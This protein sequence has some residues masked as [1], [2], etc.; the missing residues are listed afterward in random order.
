MWIVTGLGNPGREYEE[1]R[2]NIGFK[3]VE[4]LAELGSAGQWKEKNGASFVETHIPVAGKVL[5]VK[6][7]TYMNRSGEPLTRIA[8]FYKVEAEQIGVVHDEVDIPFGQLRVKAG[9]GD[10]GHNGLKSVRS[11]LGSADFVRIRVGVGRP[12]LNDEG[13]GPDIAD[14]VL[15]RFGT[16]DI[17]ELPALIDRSA[18]AVEAVIRDGVKSAQNTFN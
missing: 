10:G 7:L 14:W 8:S 2:H 6:P 12:V 18:Q 4:R 13:K 1:T 11:R 17:R 3:V 16:D 5:L 15:G 9:G